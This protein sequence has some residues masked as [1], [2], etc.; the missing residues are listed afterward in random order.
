MG[1]L[2]A[3]L[4]AAAEGARF[5]DERTIERRRVRIH[6][7]ITRLIVG[8]AQ[9]NTLL[10]CRGLHERGHEV[11]L[12][13][14]PETGPEGSLWEQAR[15]E[16]YEIIRLDSLRRAVSPWH[17]LAMRR[18]LRRLFEQR[19]PDVVHTHSSKAGILGRLAATDA[20]APVIVHTIHGMSFN[21]TQSAIARATYRWLER[22]VAPTTT[23]FI[24]VAEAMVDQAL[25]AG[26]ATRDRFHLIRSG[27]ETDRFQPDG[28]SRRLQRRRWNVAEQDVVVGTVARLFPH[29]GYEPILEAMPLIAERSPMVR[30]VWIGDGPCR[31]RYAR[32]VEEL[33]LRDRTLFAG[34]IPPEELPRCLNGFDVLLHASRWE[35][36]PRAVVQGLLT[37][38]P[39]IAFA[40]D[41]APEV[42][43]HDQT[44][45]LVPLD[46]ARG[47]AEAVISL[48]SDPD[49]RRRMGLAGRARCEPLFDW[50]KMVETIA[51]LY[52]RLR[53]GSGSAVVTSSGG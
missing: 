29:K 12:I 33:G 18:Q 25:A 51:I 50:R 47:L 15:A 19:Q 42:V 46:D 39:A 11:A 49:R 34:L 16:G 32:R 37:E 27:M 22:R 52:D 13:A 14:G 2:S 23:A 3:A 7:V 24:A 36:L 40:A 28:E 45:L 21:R 53:A 17:D 8:G 9:E 26:L 4:V 20:R 1:P 5:D 10:T 44:G 38:V 41:G 6:H 35:G 31:D 43:H 48:A 30:F